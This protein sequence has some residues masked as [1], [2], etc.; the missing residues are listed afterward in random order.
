[1]LSGVLGRQ[2]GRGASALD[3]R[4]TCWSP[5]ENDS[6]NT[7]QPAYEALLASPG[8]PVANL[9]AICLRQCVSL[10]IALSFAFTRPYELVVDPAGY[11]L[12]SSIYCFLKY[13]FH[14][15]SLRVNCL[16]TSMIPT[17]LFLSGV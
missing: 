1:M 4:K 15:S 14:L 12:R 10:P 5:A 9:V 2:L 3:S 7:D 13:V 17:Q 6:K 16:Q 11:S 8:I